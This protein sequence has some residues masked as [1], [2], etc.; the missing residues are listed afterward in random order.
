MEDTLPGPASPPESPHPPVSRRA[1]LGSLAL[2]PALAAAG[3]AS[4]ELQP[5]PELV[6]LFRRAQSITAAFPAAQAMMDRV[7]AAHTGDSHEDYLAIRH[8]ERGPYTDALTAGIRARRELADAIR[9]RGARGA[10]IDGSLV[11]TSPDGS[12]GPDDPER[13]EDD[14]IVAEPSEVIGL[15][16]GWPTAPR[17]RPTP[18]P[19]PGTDPEL[20]LLADA[21]LEAL[22]RFSRLDA[23]D[24]SPDLWDR[25]TDGE[26]DRFQQRGYRPARNAARDTG[27]ALAEAIEA[28]GLAALAHR[29]KVLVNL[30]RQLDRELGE[31][32]LSNL[33][34]IEA[35]GIAG[36]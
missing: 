32:V 7:Y 29:G 23:I 10:I 12:P 19:E 13:F 27:D 17:A 5:D 22:D 33:V 18:T 31:S 4:E 20:A 30:S 6:E 2:T 26:W 8:H 36:L 3:H 16:L 28:R 1:F 11:V 14:S 25:V 15:S 24:R 34:A 21:F 9:A 35:G